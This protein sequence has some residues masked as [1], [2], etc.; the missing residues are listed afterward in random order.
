VVDR[1]AAPPQ[2]V[3]D[4]A[5]AVGRQLQSEFLNLGTQLYVPV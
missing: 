3:R 4:P 1:H 5:I 2:F